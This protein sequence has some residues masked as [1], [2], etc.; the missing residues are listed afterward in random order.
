MIVYSATRAE[1]T[2]DVFSSQIEQK[3]LDA[4]KHR[5]GRSMV[6][7]WRNS[8]QYMNNVLL[9]GA[10]AEDAGVAIEYT[11]P[12]TS[13]RVDFIL[14][15]Q[16]ADNRDTAVIVELKQW[17]DVRATAKD[18]IV[19]TFVGGA[20]RE[21]THPSYQAWTYAALIRDFNVTVQDG[22]V[23]LHAC[24]Y[25]HNCAAADVINAEFYAATRPR[26]RRS[27][28]MTRRRSGIF[29]AAMCAGAI[30]HASSIASITD[31]CGRRRVS[32]TTCFRCCRVTASSR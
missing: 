32:S 6:A 25:L 28:A 13:K 14:T 21:V 31:G 3:I 30:V 19:E 7:S 9:D 29:S 20:V 8:L 26:L 11:V 16:D 1:F 10:I 2:G 23:S 5:V 12:L 17:T 15:G 22:D 24:A 18:A 27:C 4:L